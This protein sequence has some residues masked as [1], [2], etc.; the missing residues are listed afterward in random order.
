VSDCERPIRVLH[1]LPDLARGGGQQVVL[2]LVRGRDRNRTEISV[3]VLSPPDEMRRAFSEVGA[4]PID[5]GHRRGRGALTVGRVAWT[6]RRDDIDVLH[7]HSS[8]DR[9]IGQAAALVT[10]VPVVAHLHSPWNH[11]GI[12]LPDG[13]GPARRALGAVRGRARDGIEQRTVQAY[14][15][16]GPEVAAFHAPFVDAPLT[17]VRN[18][19]SLDRFP[20]PAYDHSQRSDRRRELGLPAD[21]PLLVMVGRLARG[22]GQNAL[23]DMAADLPGRLLLVGDGPMR[24]ELE[25][26]VRAAGTEQ[27]VEFLGDRDD[28]PD[29]L[30]VA[31]AFVFASESEGLPLA[32]LEAMAAGLPVVAMT[33]PGLVP[34]VVD[35]ENGHL[36]AQGD[37]AAFVARVGDV[38]TDRAACRLGRAG[39]DMIAARFGVDA[40]VREVTGVYDE[41]MAT[42]RA[43]RGKTA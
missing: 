35:G 28:V 23:V 17:V 27:R 26:A 1:L 22:K 6:L 32:V 33:L 2:D 19:V 30:A 13:A 14:I 24:A 40:M 31:D 9:K 12:M 10:G 18:G 5:I 21:E 16:A 29:L 8:P 25:A 36:V 4:P 15:A 3:A 39:R 37:R 7:V 34:L 42:S 41:V 20:H 43:G 11:R 38:L